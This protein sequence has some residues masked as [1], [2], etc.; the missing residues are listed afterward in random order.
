MPCLNAGRFLEPAVRS[1]LNQ[2]ECLELLVADGGSTDGSLQFLERLS[3]VDPRLRIVSTTDS[4][5]AD[6]LNKAFKAARGTLI[7]WL[8]ADDLYP[9]GALARATYALEANPQWLMLY[10]EG[11]EFN[12]STGL[13]QR[14]PTLP[15]TTGVEGF[16]SHCFICQP[17]VVFRRT[18]GLMLGPFDAHLKTAFDFDYWL[19]AFETFPYRIGYLPHLQGRTR[20]HENTI[21]NKQRT[22]ADLEFIKLV[23][24]HFGSA[25]T[26]RLHNLGLDLQ[27]GLA[28]TKAGQT[29]TELLR[30]LADQAAPWLNPKAL[31][32]FRHDWH[33][34]DDQLSSATESS[35]PSQS[36]TEARQSLAIQLLEALHPQLHPNAPGS[37]VERK[38]RCEQFI[39]IHKQNYRLLDTDKASITTR[40]LLAQSQNSRSKRP[41]GVNLIGHAYEIFGIGED[42]RMAARALQ[43]AD[44]PCCVI[45]HPA[46]NDAACTDRSIDKLVSS[47]QDGGPYAFNLVCMQAPIYARWLLKQGLSGLN[48]R[49]TITAWPWETSQWPEAWKP[50]LEVT[51][52]VWPSS[53]FTARALQEPAAQADVPLQLMHMAAEIPEPNRFYSHSSRLF[54]RNHLGLSNDAIVFVYSFD[55][56]STAIRKNPVAVLETFQQAFPLP[57]LLAIQGRSDNTHPLSERVELLIKTFPPRNF[58]PEWNWLQIRAQEDPRVHLLEANLERD[59]MLAIYGCSDVFVSLHRSEGFGRGLAEA[60]QLGLDVIA[61]DYGGNADF[62]VGPLAHPVR[63]LEVPIPRAAYPYADGHCWGEPDLNHA[64][65][66]MQEIA[67]RRLEIASNPNA[68][69]PSRDAMVLADYQKRFSF[70]E[71]GTRYRERLKSLWDNW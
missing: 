35:P 16:R 62:C 25:P 58:I 40:Q 6:A 66:L 17:S 47:D 9:P 26:T 70:I 43:A 13:R 44:V 10:G 20:L 54:T 64:A 57:Q 67:E 27:L 12:N 42:I 3:V 53:T 31:E 56:N 46:G 36:K 11:E 21:T 34:N 18:M 41:F 5:P 2:A 45:H 39:A 30:E 48:Q 32:D 50:L 15:P 65:Q 29:N 59:E 52:E 4:G 22:Q 23:A 1:V 61:T 28:E 71:A 33:L 49:Y 7:G 51:D 55:L 14:Y 37:P 8:N 38:M 68:Y 60:F 24:K 63:C 19:R 69:Y